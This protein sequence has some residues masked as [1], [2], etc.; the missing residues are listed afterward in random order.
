MNDDSSHVQLNKTCTPPP[1]ASVH[2]TR[3]L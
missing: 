1:I 2:S 3:W